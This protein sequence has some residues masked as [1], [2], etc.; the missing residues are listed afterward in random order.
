[1]RVGVL[2][3]LE[4]L[5]GLTNRIGELLDSGATLPPQAMRDLV[6]RGLRLR[7]MLIDPGDGALRDLTPRTWRLPAAAAPG[8][9]HAPPLLLNVTLTTDVHTALVTGNLNHLDTETAQRV[10]AIRAALTTA[11][12]V[13]R[14]LLD[15]PITAHTLDDDPT[16]EAPS[17]ALAEFVALRDRHPT[18]PTAGLS[19]ASAS[20]HDHTRSRASGGLTTRANMSA[21]TRRWHI[22]KTHGGWQ[23][24]RHG[25]GWRWTSPAGRTY[26]TKPYDYR[27]D[28]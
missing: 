9:P 23:V 14:Q 26:T 13:L 22:L 5:L 28:S 8:A 10:E 19:A 24:T 2:W 27:P 18:N 16:A 15:Y 17:P 25:R 4:S 21:L 11:H 12:P 6:D 1:V 20:D 3:D 7:R